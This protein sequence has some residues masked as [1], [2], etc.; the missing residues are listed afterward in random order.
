M[1][2]SLNYKRF[3]ETLRSGI[4]SDEIGFISILDKSLQH[5]KDNQIL[6]R[7]RMATKTH[8]LGSV[9]LM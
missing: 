2:M 6:T 4:V 1:A 5:Q 9:R 8:S 7:A 3:I